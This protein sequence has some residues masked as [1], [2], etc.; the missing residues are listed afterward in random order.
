MTNQ[1]LTDEQFDS[2]F[3]TESITNARRA[4]ERKYSSLPTDEI[5]HLRWRC[6]TDDF[7]LATLLG[8]DRLTT[9]LHANLCAWLARTMW[10]QFR[11]ILLP[12]GHLKTTIITIVDS[13]RAA[14]PCD[15]SVNVPYPYSLGPEIRLLVAHESQGPPG[16]ATRFLYELSSHFLSNPRLM[17]LFPE[18]VPSPR[19]QRM[20]LF[21]LEL[22]RDS[23]WAEPTFDTIGVG[24]RAQGRHYNFI[25]LDD[26]FGDKAR[27]SKAE[28]MTTIEWFDNVES[29]LIRPAEDHIDLIGTR[30]SVDDLYGHAIK[31][32]GPKLLKYIRRV[33]ERDERGKLRPIYPESFPPETI[34]RLKKKP[35]TWV[36]YSNDPRADFA[37]FNPAWKRFY[38]FVG[39][40]RVAAFLG[41][42]SISNNIRDLDR[43]ILV[44]P[45]ISKTPGIVVTGGDEKM[46]IFVLEAIKQPLDPSAFVELLFKLVRRWSPR[47]VAL[48]EVVF[49]AVYKPWIEREMQFRNFRFNIL[50]Y[51][52]PKNKVKEERVKG[53]SQYFSSGQI[54][55][56]EGQEDLLEEYDD[57]GVTED[58]HLLDALA[59]GPDIWHRGKQSQYHENLRRVE[60][61]VLNDRDVVT[62]YSR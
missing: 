2:L 23:H 51:K 47:A 49:S 38:H 40:D 10:E 32:Y 36:Q 39:R 17:G 16:G 20:N 12:R 57:F 61:Q 6:K 43:V 7:F 18:L 50:P 62:G 9:N 56:G 5:S 55:F 53:L 30:Y 26:L 45:A 60:E 58:Y 28:R 21:E 46:R 22:P 19:V 11:I 37:A 35:K 31:M 59:Q 44:D 41:N 4:A 52:P 34:A 27:E 15:K 13:I 1:P 24:G 8:Y 14:L 48:E 33:E 25:K 3:S 42:Q 54:F 29:F